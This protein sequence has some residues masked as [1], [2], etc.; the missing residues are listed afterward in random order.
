MN[1][2]EDDLQA[3]KSEER[4]FCC[5]F[6][7]KTPWPRDLFVALMERASEADVLQRKERPCILTVSSVH[8]LV[9]S[10]QTVIIF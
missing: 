6:L 8:L 2:P 10:S 5:S 9:V 1:S 4:A 7:T 3:C